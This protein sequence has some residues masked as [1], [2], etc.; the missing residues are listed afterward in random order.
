MQCELKNRKKILCTKGK[1]LHKHV[2]ENNYLRDIVDDY[3]KYNHY[4]I[5]EKKKKIKALHDINDYVNKINAGL[6]MTDNALDQSKQ[7]QRRLLH[8]IDNIKNDLDEIINSNGNIDID[9]D[10]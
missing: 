3:K 6:H 4:I 7:E 1:E 5:E 9:I 8:E 2:S 10:E